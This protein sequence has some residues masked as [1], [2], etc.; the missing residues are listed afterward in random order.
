MLFHYRKHS[1]RRNPLYQLFTE[2]KIW[3]TS[4]FLEIFQ[5][6]L[7]S[8]LLLVDMQT[9]RHLP[10]QTFLFTWIFPVSGRNVETERHSSSYLNLEIDCTFSDY[11]NN[12]FFL[13]GLWSGYKAFTAEKLAVSVND[14]GEG[15]GI[16]GTPLSPFKVSRYHPEI[17][18]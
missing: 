16:V 15:G 18:K 4:S 13:N 5:Q 6:I 9:M 17:R 2:E 11:V 8:V 3:P 12:L 1:K 10:A 14:T 7:L